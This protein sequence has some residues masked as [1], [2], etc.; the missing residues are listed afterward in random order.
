MPATVKT[1]EKFDKDI[2]K[3]KMDEMVRRRLNAGAIRSKYSDE[4]DHWLL[5]T[6][7]NIIGE[8]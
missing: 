7:W 6:E 8:Q 2:S 1:H 3:S 4:G 5:V